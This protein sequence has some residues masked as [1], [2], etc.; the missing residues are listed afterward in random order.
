MKEEFPNHF[1]HQFE[2]DINKLPAKSLDRIS[3]K[4]LLPGIL[5]GFLLSALG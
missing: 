1:S 2:L 4:I 5:L 3:L